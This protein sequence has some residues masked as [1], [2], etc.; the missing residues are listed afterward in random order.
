MKFNLKLGLI[1]LLVVVVTLTSNGLT[2]LADQVNQSTVISN[3][4]LATPANTRNYLP[5]GNEP[6]YN[7][8]PSQAGAKVITKAAALKALATTADQ[9]QTYFRGY[10]VAKTSDG[11]FYLKIVSFD[12]SYRGWIYVGTQDPSINSTNV[13]DGVKAVQT[14]KETAPST[15]LAQTPLYFTKPKASTLTYVAPDWTDYKVG[16]NLQAT[17]DYVNDAL[18][19]VKVGIKQN[20]RDSNATYYEVEDAAHPQ[21]NG[22]VKAAE[23][24][25]VKSNFDY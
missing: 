24:T 7:Q 15:V 8:L 17:T 22:W 5:T 18:K 1:T 9:G 16:R 19:V 6:L 25:T 11:K 21:V 23:V 3:S 13:S 10:R 2:T 14:F 20:N 4:A 12:K